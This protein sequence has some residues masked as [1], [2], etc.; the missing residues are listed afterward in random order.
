MNTQQNINVFSTVNQEQG[1]AARH[2]TKS[3]FGV[4]GGWGSVWLV[5]HDGQMNVLVVGYHWGKEQRIFRVIRGQNLKRFPHE[6]GIREGKGRP[7][8]CS[9]GFLEKVNVK[10]CS[11]PGLE[12][13]HTQTTDLKSAEHEKVYVRSKYSQISMIESYIGM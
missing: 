11:I 12:R 4:Q 7:R 5:D 13:L 10:F 3:G 8:F 6:G 2:A 1:L 9:V